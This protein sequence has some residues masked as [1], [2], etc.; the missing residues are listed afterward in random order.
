MQK[1]RLQLG[2]YDWA[3]F[4]GLFV[5]AFTMQVVPVI[6]LAVSNDLGFPLAAGG[7]AQGG[8][9]QFFSGITGVIAMLF[10]SF[11]AS[12]FGK[13]VT[14]ILSLTGLFLG[15]VALAFAQTYLM[16]VLLMMLAG[17]G[18]SL[19]IGLAPAI[20][21]GLHPKDSGKYITIA[22]SFWS[23]GMLL[24]VL[25]AG[26]LLGAGV[27]W[28]YVLL[29]GSTAVLL[30]IIIMLLPQKSGDN[31]PQ[32]NEEGSMR[33]AGRVKLRL[34][35]TP[36][37]WRFI[38]MLSFVT[39]SELI[40][41]LW[42]PSYVQLNFK[43][44]AEAG[45]LAVGVFA[46]GMIIS[47][48]VSGYLVKQDKIKLFILGYGLSACLLTST[49]PFIHTLLWFYVMLFVSG[50]A[51]APLWPYIQSYCVDQL[52]EYDKTV[53]LILLSIFGVCAYSVLSW[54][55]GIIATEFDNLN[56]VY[57]LVPLSYLSCIIMLCFTGREKHSDEIIL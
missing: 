11:L 41:G 46:V 40:I 38:C 9:I 57:Y 31:F 32:N 5:E 2:R 52:P 36:K 6:L 55:S 23:V 33:E 7:F 28:R 54:V 26:V 22:N 14:Y 17:A 29:L 56:P 20:A 21:H 15:I 16:F 53:V 47:R 34:L 1:R 45:G 51:I 43:A 39:C 48:F 12:K 13:R 24:T 19:L 35:R 42:T 18:G 50:L 49:F 37:F 4:M 8:L 44:S 27:S 30:P 3:V 25:L 10:G